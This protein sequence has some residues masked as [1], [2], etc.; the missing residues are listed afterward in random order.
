MWKSLKSAGFRRCVGLINAALQ[1]RWPFT[2][3]SSI[4]LRFAPTSTLSAQEAFDTL[5]SVLRKYNYSQQK[6]IGQIYTVR[7]LQML[8]EPNALNVV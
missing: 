1:F 3:T 4:E 2:G 5:Y 8:T 7:M 6:T